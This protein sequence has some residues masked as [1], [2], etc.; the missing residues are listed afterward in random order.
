MISLAK[1]WLIFYLALLLST[2]WY[3]HEVLFVEVY[4]CWTVIVPLYYILLSVLFSFFD[5]FY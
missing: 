3:A 5:A 4:S 1:G 2:R